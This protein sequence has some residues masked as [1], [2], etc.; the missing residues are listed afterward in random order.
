MRKKG[1]VVVKIYFSLRCDHLRVGGVADT[2]RPLVLPHPLGIAGPATKP[3]IPLDPRVQ[4]F[5]GHK[6]LI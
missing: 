6:F 4:S 2:Q 3:V 5:G 1:Y